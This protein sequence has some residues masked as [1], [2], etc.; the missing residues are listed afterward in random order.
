M[1][2]TH[3]NTTHRQDVLSAATELAPTI[4][5][6]ATEIEA[7]RRIP[8]DLVDLL[9]EAGCFRIVL[10]KSHG[11]VGGDL[12]A[13][14]R[15]FETLARADASV[16]WSVMIGAMS[17]CEIAALP[18]ASFD[19]LFADGRETITAGA[20]NPTG[21]IAP[22]DGGYRVT[23]RWGFV[24]GCEHASWLFGN[25]IEEVVDGVPSFRAAVFSPD[26]VVIEDTWNVSGLRG[27]GS[28]HIR[29][30]NVWVPADRT[31]VPLQDPPCIDETVMHI[32]IPARGS[33]AIA[34]VAI[35]IAQG[36][37]D[38]IQALAAGKIPLLSTAPL[39]ENPL[40]HVE[41]AEGDT[42]LRAARALLHETA[43]LVWNVAVAREQLTLD[44]RA[45][46]RS[47][48]VW[49]TARASEVVE[50]AYRW[51]GGTSIYADSPLQRRLRD[52]NAV[53][54]HFAVKRD[55]LRTAGAIL[56]GL[57]VTVTL[58]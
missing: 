37:L 36:A 21:S 38:D 40:F 44:Q 55:T 9:A 46:V 8:P 16:G 57:E 6:R 29:V 45:R 17:S 50:N 14:L 52:V 24:S 5:A 47:A 10:P 49:A 25:C 48:A 4:E 39:A 30:D 13:A 43:E 56:A 33:L 2:T 42:E 15:V 54:Q 22:A 41:L 28:H 1:T 26:Q 51:G 23:G 11:G 20:F 18:R 58:F 35:G 34:S 31:F 12:M 7:A 3:M 53:T 27:T 32:S 19:A